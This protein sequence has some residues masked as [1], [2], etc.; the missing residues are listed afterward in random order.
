MKKLVTIFLTFLLL[1][2]FANADY[3]SNS[4]F[5]VEKSMNFDKTIRSG[6]CSGVIPYPELSHSD[7]E[8]FGKI[9]DEIHD[10]I[11]IYAICNKEK[12]NNFSVDFDIPE[13]AS[14]DFFSVR[15]LTKKD[16]NL[17]RID[18]LNFNSESGNIL[19]PDNIFNLLSNHMMAKMVDLSEGHLPKKC[20]WE[21][22]LDKIE[23]RDIQF[24]I[25][26]RE[27]HI[28]FNAIPGINN[29]VDVKIPEYF[30]IGNRDHDRG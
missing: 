7:E 10:F 19:V 16:G 3:I 4:F 27:W 2:L 22:L 15:W 9:N 6:K 30:L 5:V 21:K 13:S 18:V 17:W 20:S 11:E 12:R 24:Y 29:V 28:V 26:D 1:P 23:A 25:K 8:L 14:K